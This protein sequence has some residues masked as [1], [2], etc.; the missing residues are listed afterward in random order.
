MPGKVPCIL[1]KRVLWMALLAGQ[2]GIAAA[3]S[4]NNA[5]FLDAIAKS[6]GGAVA[7]I[8][9]TAEGGDLHSAKALAGIL[10]R[11]NGVPRDLAQGRSWAKQVAAVGDADGQLL[12]YLAT[13]LDPAVA[14]ADEVFAYENLARAAAQGHIPAL[15]ALLEFYSDKLGPENQKRAEQLLSLHPELPDAAN[16]RHWLAL[17]KH[18]GTTRA[19][20]ELLRDS[21]GA[22]M[23]MAVARAGQRACKDVKPQKLVI[24]SDVR[25]AA[26][27]PLEHPALHESYLTGGNWT[28]HWTFS[29]CGTET[30]VEATFSVDA[31]S[32]ANYAF[33]AL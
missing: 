7:A 28:E 16:Y 2:A 18:W 3:Q 21:M 4:G 17:V 20:P 9:K 25:S 5:A 8:R 1:L 24:A 32:G 26:Y 30:T 10:I 29:V 33:K 14:R 15:A 31:H 22:A 13:I 23:A 6:E 11:G 27:L 19:T 12:V